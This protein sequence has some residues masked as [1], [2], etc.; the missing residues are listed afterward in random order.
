M[1]VAL[2]KGNVL[3]IYSTPEKAHDATRLHAKSYGNDLL[4]YVVHSGTVYD[5][6]PLLRAYAEIYTGC[7]E[8]G[9]LADYPCRTPKG[10]W[11]LAPHA[12]RAKNRRG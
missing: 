4:E 7:P 2:H 6:P 5:K 1:N 10:S 11:K 8:C 12:E 3:G 9:A